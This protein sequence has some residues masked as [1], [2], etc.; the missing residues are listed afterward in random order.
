[1]RKI[2]IYGAILIVG[3]LIA[4]FSFVEK[5]EGV[6]P[7]MLAARANNTAE[8]SMLLTEGAD[9]DRLSAYRWTAL[10]FAAGAGSAEAVRTLLDAGTDV[11]HMS[12]K[13][14]SARFA[15]RGGY[16]PTNALSEA[17]RYGHLNIAYTLMSAGANIDTKSLALAGGQ[18]SIPLLERMVGLGGNVNEV[19][20]SEFHRTALCEAAK[21][22]DG[23][24]V[25][26]LLDH[27]A[28]PNLSIPHNSTLNCA[29]RGLHPLIVEIL[30]EL[31]ADPNGTF[32]TVD[33]RALSES[34]KGYTD[35]RKYDRHLA[36]IE[37]LLR[38][39]A[40]VNL[41]QSNEDYPVLTWV[42]DAMNRA[43]V[44]YD[45]A[46]DNPE[47]DGAT[48]ERFRRSAEHRTA[49]YNLLLLFSK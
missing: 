35:S 9:V 21:A 16:E 19:S 22:G 25:N 24:V 13:V 30:I 3:L 40:D 48:V 47:Y 23:D 11:N 10:T 26:W 7:L 31:G 41:H 6:T 36:V 42:E 39:G 28:D 18:G 2:L 33:R 8:I 37:I 4:F 38:L 34:V 49:V 17:I 27:G 12:R 45:E 5:S 43:I 1:M 46:A 29:V 44:G 20:E 15:T 14:P 32:G